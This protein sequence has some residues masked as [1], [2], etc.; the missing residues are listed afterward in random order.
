MECTHF[1]LRLETTATKQPKV[2]KN[3]KSNALLTKRFINKLVIFCIALFIVFHYSPTITTVNGQETSE[4]EWEIRIENTS[5]CAGDTG[6]IIHFYGRWNATISSYHVIWRYDPT[7]IEIVDVTLEG[8]SAELYNWSIDW[9]GQMVEGDYILVVAQWTYLLGSVIPKGSGVLFNVVVDIKADASLGDTLLELDTYEGFGQYFSRFYEYNGSMRRPDLINGVITIMECVENNPPNT[10]SDPTPAHQ[11]T[12]VPVDDDLSWNG[13]DPDGDLVTYDVYFSTSNPPAK[14]VNNQSTLSYDPGTMNYNTTYYWQIVSWDEHGASTTGSIWS[15]TTEENITPSQQP[16]ETSVPTSVTEGETFIVT[17]TV[18]ETPVEAVFV[19]FLDTP[20]YTDINGIVTLEAPLV[21]HDTSYSITVSKTGYQSATVIISVLNEA[22]NGWVTGSV[23]ETKGNTTESVKDAMVCLILSDEN[24][25][26]TSKCTFTDDQGVYTIEAIAGTYTMKAG[27]TGYITVTDE[28][29]I[30]GNE[31]TIVNITLEKGST[32][33]PGVFPVI[34]EENRVEIENAIDEGSV[35]AEVIIQPEAGT[36]DYASLVVSYDAVQINPKEITAD[37]I[38]LIV[39]GNETDLG[40]TIVITADGFDFDKNIRIEY[41]GESIPLA[42][43]IADVLDPWNDGH[44][45]EH[46]LVIGDDNDK[47]LILVS[48]PHFSEHEI[49][50]SLIAEEIS[51]LTQFVV[52]IAF[53]V[54]VLAALA[55]FRK[56]K[57]D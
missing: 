24:N 14:V 9:P 16:L 51:Y 47:A 20:Y 18:D 35:G 48:V 34:I 32:D 25:V 56:G 26:I 1:K 21:E 37:R 50:I 30:R 22:I 28:I 13:G 15:F 39:G 31:I 55:M 46:L 3:N 52:L 27:K 10:P 23:R 5:G 7:V 41:D 4:S 29:T 43:D 19:E 53:I 2:Y 49:T 40:K 12:E 42:D 6:H 54:I 36:Q 45:P 44:H 8:T 38:S 57:E 17:V 33:E 11:T